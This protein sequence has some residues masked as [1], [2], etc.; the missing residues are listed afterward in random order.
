MTGTSISPRNETFLQVVQSYCQL[1]KPRI[2]PLLLF[3]T[4]A[5]MWLAGEGRV[6][7]IN[8]LITLAGGTFAAAS[9]Q[10]LNCIY[11]KDIDYDM[12]RTRKRPIPS[13]RVQPQHALLFAIVLAVLSFSLLAG[14]VN[15]LSALLA[16]SG[17][18]VYMLVY[19]HWLKRHSTQNIVIGG[20]AGAIPTLVG[21]AAV[22]GELSWTAWLLFAIVFFWTPPH[23]WALAMMI[24]DDYEQV[25]VPML[26][27]VKGVENTAVQVFAYTLFVVP[28]TFALIYPLGKSGWIY[29]GFAAVLGAV[30]ITK[31]WELQQSPEEK[32]K[33]R[34]LFKYSILYMMLLCTGMVIDSL[35]GTQQMIAFVTDAIAYL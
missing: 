14:F 27:V 30:F 9:A 19:T 22:T 31:A 26:P 21:W 20:S 7:P 15:L 10:T 11:D 13:G 4:T 29:G 23:F 8:V 5:A 3:T 28:L 12:E 16:L 32:A 17:I 24:R 1:T 25:N 35:P 2:I 18:F 33:A 6:D 34:S